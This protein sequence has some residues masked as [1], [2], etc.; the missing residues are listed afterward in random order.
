VAAVVVECTAKKD[1]QQTREKFVSRRDGICDVYYPKDADA[2]ELVSR[3]DGF[4]DT[5]LHWEPA[6][7]DTI[8]TNYILRLIRAVHIG[9]YV[10]EEDGTPVPGAKVA[11]N[12]NITRDNPVAALAPENHEF[13]RIEI[14]ADAEGRWSLDR[15]APDVLWRTAG[16]AM[17]PEHLVKGVLFDNINQKGAL[18][19]LREGR[20]VFK[21]SRGVTVQGMV[22]DMQGKP[23]PKAK[24]VVGK[25]GKG[26]FRDATTLDDGSFVAKSCRTGET[27]VAVSA[28]GFAA[29]VLNLNLEADPT[30][31]NIIL[32]SGRALRLKV[33]DQAGR[34]IAKATIAANL[35]S[36]FLAPLGKTDTNGSASVQAPAAGTVTI[37]IEA[38]GYASAEAEIA[39][40][41]Q[42]HSIAL[43]KE[44][45]LSG[46]VTDAATGRPIPQFRIICGTP[47][48]GSPLGTN[49]S[50]APSPMS[51][52]WLKFGNGKFRLSMKNFLGHTGLVQERGFMVKFEADGYAPCVSRVIRCE[53][54]NVQLDA[55]LL[56]AKSVKVTVLNPDGRPAAKVEVGLLEEG[57][58]LTLSAGHLRAESGG[59]L[60]QTDS[61]GAFQLTPDDAIQRVIALNPQG[62]A[63]ASPSALAGEP[64]L[65]L[66]PFGRLEGRWLVRNQPAP[67]K[68]LVLEFEFQGTG[69][70]LDLDWNAFSAT[71]DDQGHFVFA[72]VPPGKFRL[73]RPVPEGNG[74]NTMEPV[75]D[76]TV[77]PGETTTVAIGE[78]YIVSLRLRWPADILPGKNTRT[79]VF[80]HTP[81]PEP[82]ATIMHDPQALAQWAQTPDIQAKLRAIRGYEFAEGADGHWTADA[83]PAGTTYRLEARAMD[84]TATNGL[85]PFIAYGQMTVTLPAEPPTGQFDAG[86]LV[87]RRAKQSA[88]P[89]GA[90]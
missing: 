63:T 51:E 1:K 10:R 5:I 82:P 33:V 86:E 66:Q 88:A 53:E 7:E 35:P 6:Q 70:R 69:A 4:A 14:E 74:V 24:V 64:T 3:T 26:E 71:T 40:D 57:T 29:K 31:L 22:V 34:P 89:A 32:E 17:A 41:G 68:K 61:E 30:S 77:R 50:F 13:K 56:P 87:L 90:R 47:H 80:L 36:S 62:F 38:S 84:E 11:F 19:L 52:D 45:V 73:T 54:G 78:G 76:A 58:S 2:L 81:G 85:P 12:R 15:I 18:E 60:L 27:C 28:K 37:K 49:V 67:Q 44:T 8:P 16:V 75:A 20:F 25:L 43:T 83:V 46:A 65:Q 79:G 9:G 48:F 23:V 59:G 39:A 72:Q 21:L 55:A 42:E